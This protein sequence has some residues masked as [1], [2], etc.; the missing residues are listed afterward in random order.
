MQQQVQQQLQQL[1]QQLQQ[2]QVCADVGVEKRSCVNCVC[3]QTRPAAPLKPDEE[4]LKQLTSV[5]GFKEAASVRALL[6][7]R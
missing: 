3:Q 4:G 6:L 2:V 7:H 5:M 1:H